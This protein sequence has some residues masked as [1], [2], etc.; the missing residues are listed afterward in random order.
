MSH[1]IGQDAEASLAGGGKAPSAKR[2]H[3][4]PAGATW[5]AEACAALHLHADQFAA[6]KFNSLIQVRSQTSA[7]L[8]SM[9]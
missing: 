5:I 7:C 1:W 8:R 2:H 6:I 9:R 3:L 4:Y